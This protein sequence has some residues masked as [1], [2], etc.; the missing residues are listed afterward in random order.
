[1]ETANTTNLY[2]KSL[3]KFRL[4]ELMKE[5]GDFKYLYS[6]TKAELIQLL[7]EMDLK[8]NTEK[9]TCQRVKCGVSL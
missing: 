7:C 4:V 8:K 2:Y 1:M 9:C 5:R 3:S 6:M